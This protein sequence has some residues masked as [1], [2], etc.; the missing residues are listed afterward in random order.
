MQPV[1]H[2]PF[3]AAATTQPRTHQDKPDHEHEL[4]PE[5]TD[6]TILYNTGKM[7]ARGNIECPR[8][9]LDAGDS[10]TGIKTDQ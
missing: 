8:P 2:L 6:L 10:N 1:T 9:P 5:I 3:L 7:K 4:L